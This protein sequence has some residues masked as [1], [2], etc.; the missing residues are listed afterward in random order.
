M[1]QDALGVSMAL[2]AHAS[3]GAAA[4]ATDPVTSRYTAGYTNLAPVTVS[5]DNSSA[6]VF[7]DHAQHRV[8]D[9]WS[10]SN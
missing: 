8:V 9:E 1:D 6:A 3:T 7:P 2:K 5:G 4:A 10:V